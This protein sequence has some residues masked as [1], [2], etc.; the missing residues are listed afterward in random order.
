MSKAHHTHDTFSLRS[1]RVKTFFVLAFAIFAFAIVGVFSHA[2]KSTAGFKSSE[3]AFTD[4]SPH[5]MEI[6]PASCPS[7]P[8]FFGECDV[9]ITWTCADGTPA[10]NN[11][12]NQCPPPSQPSCFFGLCPGGGSP[13]G[14]GGTP[15]PVCPI[16][17]VGQGNYCVFSACPAG[18]TLS[19]TQCVRV[20]CP[21]GF[22]LSGENCI[23]PASI[24]F[25]NFSSTNPNGPF[26]ASGHLQVVPI[27]VKSGDTV[28]VYWNVTNASS[29]SVIG[30]DGDGWNT[31]SSGTAGQTSSAITAQT[32][33]TL[34]CQ[35]LPGAT[36]ASVQES[37]VVN[38]I[39]VFKEL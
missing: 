8:H 27:L 24:N 19:G 34:S 12:V 31:K 10:P 7:S 16:G 5:G 9:P 13:R 39:P 35:S 32:T 14:G 20:S 28:Q 6:V 30:T 3:V 2:G 4:A 26:I 23:P 1:I 15:N 11:D 38:I 18:Y 29:C 33:F 21:F 22:T 37:Q 36:P 17:Y 25:V